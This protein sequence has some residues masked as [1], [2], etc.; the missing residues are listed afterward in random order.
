MKK[1]DVKAELKVNGENG[2]VSMIKEKYLRTT[3][4]YEQVCRN[5]IYY[6]IQ[7]VVNKYK[8]VCL[9]N[10]V[11]GA[12]EQK[13]CLGHFRFYRTILRREMVSM[14]IQMCWGIWICLFDDIEAEH[15]DIIKE[16]C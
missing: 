13:S 10:N 4:N 14:G 6:C 2:I 5:F 3:G 7:D 15:F 11:A 8:F 1:N 12:I 9:V 16:G